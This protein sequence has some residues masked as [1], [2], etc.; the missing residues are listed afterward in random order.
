M[1]GRLPPQP[2]IGCGVEVVV[3]RALL[4]AAL[5]L[6]AAAP[7][8]QAARRQVPRGFY[9][10][11]WDRSGT[12]AD[13]RAQDEQWAL[14]ARSGVES[15]RTVFSWAAAQP[16]AGDPI[17]FEATDPLVARASLHGVRLLP[18]VLGTP[19]WARLYPPRD[20]SPP[21]RAE[22]YAAYV[23]A[24]IGRYGPDGSFW[25]EHPELPP[26]P[27]R[28]WQVWNEPHIDANWYTPDGPWAPRY[29]RLLKATHRAITAADPGAKVVAAAV[30]DYAWRHLA[31][32]YREGGRRSFDVAAINFFSVRPRNVA[33]AIRVL[34]RTMRR[35]RDARKPIWLTEVTWPAAKGRDRPSAAWQRSWI[36]TDDGMATRLRQ[37]YSLLVR[38]RV[39]TNRALVG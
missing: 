9:G 34:R 15:V 24:L 20:S 18:V 16:E 21:Q 11:M 6:L 23:T 32:V 22:D 33:R 17:G 28:H 7:A 39:P 26:L 36:Q 37:A 19:G 29:T 35:N 3:R 27:L 31:H 5:V 13:D 1:D 38:K 25:S 30:A 4:M 12:R 8:A 10:V 14:M 2:S